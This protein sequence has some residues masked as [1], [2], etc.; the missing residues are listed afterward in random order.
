MF[1][2]GGL[3]HAGLHDRVYAMIMHNIIRLLAM[4]D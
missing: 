2:V 4:Y 1:C 3:Q